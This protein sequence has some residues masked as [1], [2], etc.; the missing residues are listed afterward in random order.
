MVSHLVVV[1]EEEEEEEEEGYSSIT[2][3]PLLVVVG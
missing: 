1:K 2:V 3:R